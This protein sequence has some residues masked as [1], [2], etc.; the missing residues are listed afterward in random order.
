MQLNIYREVFVESSSVVESIVLWYFYRIAFHSSLIVSMGFSIFCVNIVSW[1][2]NA[3]VVREWGNENMRGEFLLYRLQAKRE[4]HLLDWGVLEELPVF[5][6]FL[7]RRVSH[8]PHS[9]TSEVQEFVWTLTRS[10]FAW[11][12]S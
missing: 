1:L 6:H 8:A 11:I 12:L 2:H 4:R 5:T 3:M 9:K 10:N 7:P